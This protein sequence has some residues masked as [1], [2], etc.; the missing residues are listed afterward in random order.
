[1]GKDFLPRREADLVQWMRNAVSVLDA[2]YAAYGLTEQQTIALRDDAA[3]FIELHALAHN[4][5]TRSPANIIR[6]D[7][8]RVRAVANARQI[9]RIAQSNPN[10][11]DAMRSNLGITVPK[12]S[13]TLKPVPMNAPM[14]HIDSVDGRTVVVRLCGDSVI[15][16][17]RPDDIA[18]ATIFTHVG[19]AAPAHASEWKFHANTTRTL[20]SI[21]F[22]GTLE[23]GATVWVCAFWRN[24]RDEP[25]PFSDPIR[26]TF[27]SAGVVKN[28]SL[29]LAA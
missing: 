25:G 7:E 23:P 28:A 12:G 15:R 21:Q 19:P 5:E 18:G 24:D 10:T 3:A 8:A 9:A 6:K 22:P 20:V 17:G 16:R 13:A 2:E 26:W 27:G 11:T 4:G 1:M 14:L 29:K